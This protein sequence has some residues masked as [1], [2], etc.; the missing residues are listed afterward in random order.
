VY[1]RVESGGGL[2]WLFISVAGLIDNPQAIL[3][4]NSSHHLG[5][6]LEAAQLA[7]AFLCGKR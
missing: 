1:D 3:K 7:P 2:L 5:Q 4:P 6:E